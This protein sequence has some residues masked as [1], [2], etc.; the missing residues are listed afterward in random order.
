MPLGQV[1]PGMDCTG[2][3]VVQGTTISSFQVHVVSVVQSSSGTRILVTVSGPAVDATGV[4]EGMSGSPVYCPEPDGTMANAGAISEG[5]GEYGNKAA[6]VTPIE[7]MLGEPAQPP[8]DLPRLMGRPEPLGRPL[9]VGGLSP[10]LL[11][12]LQRAAARSGWT[13][14]SAP[15]ATTVVAFPAQDL[16]PGASVAAEY[17]VGAVTTGAIGTVTYRDGPTVYAFGHELD[18]AGR[19]ELLLDDAYVYYVA[20]DP[21]PEDSPPSY[22]LAAPGHALGT[23]T[24]DTPAAVIGQVGS[25][26][27]LIPVQVTAHDLD[28]GH[29]VSE[30]TQ[31][32]DETDVG[33]PLGTS[34]L[35]TLAPVAIG[36]G[37]I[38]VYNGPPAAESGRM[39][40]RLSLR[41]SRR[42]LGFCKRYVGLGA[43]G[44]AGPVPPE[45]SGGIAADVGTAFGILEEVRFARLHVTAV[46]ATIS[47]QRGLE[48]A[49]I[50]SAHG[51]RRVRAGHDARVR[52]LLRM[53]RGGP[54][55][56]T[57]RLRIPRGARGRV[58]VTIRGPAFAPAAPGSAGAVGQQLTILLGNSLSGSAPSGAPPRSIAAV[59]K[60][61]ALLAPF[62]GLT[63]SF[64]G[65][66]RRRVYT[67]PALLISGRAKLAFVV[68]R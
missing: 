60:A 64:G 36:Q 10:S 67:D 1:Q 43:A 44:D 40:L 50:V 25:G 27:P 59:R 12:V 49:S 3:T 17:S 20:N 56:V 18:G 62:D 39:C 2:E 53:Y 4:A 55:T 24:S 31:V 5:I 61:I 21:N 37:A 13:V 19:R 26:P 15:P 46:D 42:P 51:P 7:Q 54:R 28:T 41:E 23:V 33:L 6:L 48:E 9:T 22:K 8:S 30:Q 45:L 63:A 38:D 47:A 11:S 14:L 16:V 29:A 65:G 68:V 58:G 32:A 52:L 57:F 35:D 34:M 66:P